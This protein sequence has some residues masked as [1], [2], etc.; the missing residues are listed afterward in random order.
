MK[1]RIISSLILVGIAY[2]IIF[3][4][5]ATVFSSFLFLVSLIITYE[6]HNMAYG[7]RHRFLALSLL[8]CAIFYWGMHAYIFFGVNEFNLAS[9]AIIFSPFYISVIELFRKKPFFSKHLFLSPLRFALIP[10]AGLPLLAYLYFQSIE[11]LIVCLCCIWLTD[12]SALIG[13]KCF[14]KIQLSQLSPN[15]T[16]EGS[17]AA[18]TCN[19]IFGLIL[20]LT[21]NYS[22]LIVFTLILTSCFAQLGDLHASFYKRQFNCKD[23]GHLI[24]G[25]G[26]FYD[27]A[28]STLFA[29]PVFFL[30]ISFL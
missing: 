15:K 23:A 4:T 5:N 3:K 28:D 13:G 24:P 16:I 9:N 21:L 12:I 7:A 25:H 10:A 1:L 30:L 22:V 8:F 29:V 27:R 6:C 17:I 20:I 2:V 26:G 19:A 14:G 11:L 18:I